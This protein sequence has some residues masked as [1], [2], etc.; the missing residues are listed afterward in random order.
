[1]RDGFDFNAD[2][3]SVA[4]DEVRDFLREI[5]DLPIDD[6]VEVIN[7][8]RKLIHEASPFKDEPVDLVS[9]VK[10]DFVTAND[11]NPNSVAP[12]EMELLRLSIMA[13]G[14]TQP[15]VT[16][17]EDGTRIV[18]DGFHR[19][20]VGKECKDVRERVKG[21][22][23]VVQIK[24]SQTDR[25]DRMAATIRHN[26]ARGKHR[27]EAMSEIV[28][29]L[30]RRNWTDDKIGRELGMDPDEVLR[31]TQISGLAEMFADK[32]FSEAWEPGTIEPG[33]EP[34]NEGFEEEEND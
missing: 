26:R 7:F 13:D 16:N 10:A 5:A 12:P 9:W 24:T 11:Y 6:Q 33:E 14:Y 28:L 31:L 1:M 30:K 27:V 32:E 34:I 18:V 22:L 4:I 20:R 21:Y 19:N 8:C 2:R 25:G 29:E 23:P 3:K 15:I 17:N